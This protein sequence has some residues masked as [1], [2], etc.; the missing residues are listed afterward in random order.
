M[1][2]M[3]GVPM[4]RA[5]WWMGILDCAKKVHR[6]RGPSGRDSHGG[7]HF[8]VRKKGINGEVCWLQY[9]TMSEFLLCFS[10]NRGKE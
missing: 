9:H 10:V 6:S 2:V 5:G 3:V 4:A 7:D 1:M 8:E